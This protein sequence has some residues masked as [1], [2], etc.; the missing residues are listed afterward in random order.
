MKK[1]F[2]FSVFFILI[3][4]YILFSSLIPEIY[5][6]STYTQITLHK[7]DE[8]TK[9]MFTPDGE[10]IIYSFEGNIWMMNSNGTG[11]IILTEGKNPSLSKD[12]TKLVYEYEENIYIYDMLQRTKNK[13]VENGTLPQFDFSGEKIIFMSLEEFSR[14]LYCVEIETKIIQQISEVSSERVIE[15]FTVSPRDDLVAFT[16]T[17][18][19][20]NTGEGIRGT[21]DIWI[22]NTQQTFKECI[23]ESSSGGYPVFSSDGEKIAYI[24]KGYLYIF[25]L[26][27]GEKIKIFLTKSGESFSKIKFFPSFLNENTKILAPFFIQSENLSCVSL[28]EVTGEKISDII[29]TK[30]GIITSCLSSK[31]DTVLFLKSKGLNSFQMAIYLLKFLRLVV[32][33]EKIEECYPLLF[34]NIIL[35]PLKPVFK[36]IGGEVRWEEKEKKIIFFHEVACGEIKLGNKEILANNEKYNLP[37]EPLTVATYT[38]L[39]LKFF[40]DILGCVTKFEKEKFVVYLNWG[41]E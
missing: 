17:L 36:K 3:K 15:Y 21:E 14:N 4:P 32:N 12:G 26:K 30:E 5:K 2:F 28:F 33:E 18:I 25:D 38:Y 6:F 40:E 22:I 8:N 19:N 39:P 37:I 41:K 10:K 9:A 1:I 20:P 31:D 34:R 24:S 23:E 27:K 16:S 11:K 13:I 7:G 35:V 29:R